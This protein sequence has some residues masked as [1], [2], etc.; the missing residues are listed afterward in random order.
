MNNVEDAQGEAMH[1]PNSTKHHQRCTYIQ[2]TMSITTQ[3]LLVYI[4]GYR[5]K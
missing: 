4:L 3:D 1:T 2:S 5:S